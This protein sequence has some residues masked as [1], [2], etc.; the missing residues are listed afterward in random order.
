MPY[1]RELAL[2]CFGAM[3]TLLVWSNKP[4]DYL[5]LAVLYWPF[6]CLVPIYLHGLLRGRPV[7]RW[8][9][10]I[11]AVVPMLAVVYYTSWMGWTLRTMHPVLVPGE[12]AGIYAQ[13]S[14]AE[15]VGEVVEYIRA[16]SQPD[17]R[18]AIIACQ[19]TAVWIW[20]SKNILRSLGES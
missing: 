15:M 8:A 13:Q 20:R 7:L 10:A 14:E 11:A 9:T 19:L 2:L 17:E 12:R 1:L 3:L 4:Q 18:V 16:N 6:L 5:H